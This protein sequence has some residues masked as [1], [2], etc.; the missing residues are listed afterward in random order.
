MHKWLILI[1]C[2]LFTITAQSS[3]NCFLATENGKIIKQ[4]GECTK[5]HSPFSTFKIPLAV[6]G[7][8]AGILKT[9]L[10]P[11]LAFTPEL[12]QQ[13]GDL[14]QPNKYPI[15]KLHEK[16]Q[17]P[18]SWMQ[19]S[20]IWYSQEITK[21]LGKENFIVYTN[22]FN[23]GNKDVSGTPGKNDGLS[24]AWL[25]SSLQISPIEQVE[26]LEKL[27]KNELPVSKNAQQNT[28]Q[29]IKQEKIW[30]DWQL[31]GKTGG[32]YKTGWFV[33]W[34]EKGDRRII[35]AQYV[36]AENLPISAGRIAKEIVK[37]NLISLII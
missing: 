26:F 4:E 11:E 31:F 9:P 10:E 17:T 33:G 2:S 21:H 7:F 18:T 34:V 16:V 30:E 23:Y 25:G 24:H 19:Y 27:S 28:I 35:F 14:F 20:V 3:E 13:L 37:D 22:K 12:K 36:E 29:I 15:M 6:M 1:V 8:D 5:R 32:S